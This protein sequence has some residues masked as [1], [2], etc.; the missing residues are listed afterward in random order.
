MLLN[1]ARHRSAP[2]S[3][4]V[5]NTEVEKHNPKGGFS[6]SRPLILEQ[7]PLVTESTSARASGSVTR[8]TFSGNNDPQT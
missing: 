2:A 8:Q 4:H 1:P 7:H 6:P 3:P 5:S